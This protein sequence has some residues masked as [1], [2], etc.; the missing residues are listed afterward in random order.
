[1]ISFPL[2]K[3]PTFHFKDVLAIAQLMRRYNYLPL[4]A[5]DKIDYC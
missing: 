5:E 3:L 2:K 1:M 4:I